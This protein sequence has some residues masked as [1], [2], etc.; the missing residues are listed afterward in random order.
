M[1]VDPLRLQATLG[2]PALAR[3]L[4]TLRRRLER[5]RPL[6][7]TITLPYPRFSSKTVQGKPLHT[8]TL[9]GRIQEIT[10]PTKTSTLYRLT[11]T[12][13]R[14]IS[15]AELTELA[16]AKIET[17]TPTTDKRK[18]LGADFRRSDIRASWQALHTNPNAAHTYQ[19]ATFHCICSS[20]TY[21]RTL[22]E[23]VGNALKTHGLALSI[24]RTQIGRYRSLPFGF[25]YWS[26]R[27]FLG[28]DNS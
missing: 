25:G 26:E 13:L 20:G 21:M 24:K 16:L 23:V 27:F 14:T 19:I 8:W 12:S 17:I 3:L 28:T 10:I 15:K 7:G 2:D 22:A 6:T 5:G 1:A 11:P 18:E 4:D 9:E